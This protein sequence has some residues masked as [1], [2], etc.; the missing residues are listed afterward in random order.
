MREEWRG[1]K[2]LGGMKSTGRVRRGCREAGL[3]RGGIIVYRVGILEE[4]QRHTAGIFKFVC[5]FC[6]V[7]GSQS[8]GGGVG[9]GQPQVG[10]RGEI[11]THYSVGGKSHM[12]ATNGALFLLWGRHLGAS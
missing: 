4:R 2:E 3:G 9:G 1:C 11:K 6:T 12:K 7:C 10:G 8:D 5:F